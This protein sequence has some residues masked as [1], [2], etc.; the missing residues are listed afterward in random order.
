MC[1]ALLLILL[2]PLLITATIS[3]FNQEPPTPPEVPAT[4]P[5]VSTDPTTPPTPL[6][7]SPVPTAPVATTSAGEN[8][9]SVAAKITFGDVLTVPP[10][11]DVARLAVELVPGLTWEEVNAA[12]PPVDR[13][14][15]GDLEKF[16]LLDLAAEQAHQ[17][18]F[19]LRSITEHANWYVQTGLAVPQDDLTQA[20]GYF[21]KELYP[22]VVG[23]F[24]KNRYTGENG[25]PRLTILNADIRGAGGYFSSDDT[26]PPI[27]APFSNHREVIYI[28]AAAIP[29]GGPSYQEVLAHELSHAIHWRHDPTEV[30]WVNEGLA[31]YAITVIGSP[32]LA[33]RQF[34]KTGPVSLVHWPHGPGSSVANYGG[35][36]LFVHYLLEHY[37]SDDG[38]Q[39]LM[40]QP[41]DGTA[42]VTAY[43]GNAGYD[44]TFRD[45]FKDW[46]VANLLAQPDGKYGYQALQDKPRIRK[47]TADLPQYESSIPQYSV[48]YLDLSDFP[49]PVRMEFRGQT[50]NALLPTET[51]PQGCWWSNSGDSINSTL[52]T[53]LD[54][55]DL[56]HAAFSYELW[57]D[58]E[59]GWDYAYVAASLDGGGKWTILDAPGATAEDPFGK[60]F[61]VGYT[62]NS[63]GWATASVDLSEFAGEQVLLR[64]QYVT[65]DAVNG[66]GLCL[67]QAAVISDESH[68]P[69]G[70]WQPLGFVLTGNRV[71]Q[72][73]IV[74][75]IEVS[76]EPRI[77]TVPLDENNEGRFVVER[78]DDL[79]QLVVAVAALAP[80][81]RQRAAYTLSFE[82]PGTSQP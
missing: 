82:P 45:V 13:N 78:P 29:P 20:A 49:G 5:G 67:R 17:P 46:V 76:A 18:E 24:G 77:T 65:D 28:N 14:Q 34:L 1:K 56:N 71:P 50:E 15:V 68:Q 25:G 3:C 75:V 19:E 47:V 59:D 40:K 35:A 61:G 74:Q 22:R 7:D 32:L 33:T 64:F 11:A 60:N 4:A 63:R 48:Q 10:D 54:L 57:Y 39:A 12:T 58:I 43:L 66:I 21:E 42:G 69:I 2:T 27:V 72:D 38:P 53:S 6:V 16:W 41:E 37:P 8:S 80:K 73:Y 23:A 81:T 62:G 51:G 30:V 26:Q 44:A 9:A 55:K 70:D 36:S 52:T 79:E 31:E